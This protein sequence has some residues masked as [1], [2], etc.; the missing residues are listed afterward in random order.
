MLRSFDSNS[1]NVTAGA[2]NMPGPGAP[3]MGPEILAK[4]KNGMNRNIIT[5]NNKILLGIK[6]IYMLYC[7]PLAIGLRRAGRAARS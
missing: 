2:D 7:I 4:T 1:N 3:H 5:I 6:N